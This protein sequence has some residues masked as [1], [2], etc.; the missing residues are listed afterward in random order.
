[1][2]DDYDIPDWSGIDNCRGYYTNW[3][4]NSGY[5]FNGSNFD[6]A[7]EKFIRSY[8][9][10]GLIEDNRIEEEKTLVETMQRQI[11][12]LSS[13]SLA[14]LIDEYSTN[15]VL[16]VDVK[17]NDLLVFLLRRGYID[18][19]YVDYINYFKATTITTDDMNYILGIKN[20]SPKP[21]NYKLTRTDLVVKRLQPYEF[22]QEVIY[23][24]DLLECLLSSEKYGEKLNLYI[25][26]LSNGSEAS[27]EFIDEFIDITKHKQRFI[28]ILATHWEEMW[29]SIF[30]NSVLTLDRKFYYLSL[31][32][33]YASIESIDSMNAN[34]NLTAFFVS[35]S[36]VLQ[37]LSSIDDEKTINVIT[38]LEIKF[39]DIQIENVSTRILDYVFDNNFYNVN[40]E[41]IN[42][43]VEY[44]DKELVPALKTKNYSTLLKLN[45]V[46]LLNYIN[47]NIWVYTD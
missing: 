15:A 37:R 25:K 38:S 30:E 39:V 19:K 5:S 9:V 36:D 18:E 11:Y 6:T 31:L 13:K 21:Y 8:K 16:S 34:G 14:E 26:Q 29:D 22:E 45:Y 41:M 17:S 10:V 3:S 12:E 23:N 35:N 2:R 43:I 42:R 20:L 27:W 44:K 33:S 7:Y 47:D 28:K 40:F 32:I 46:P 1:M 24:F 4:G